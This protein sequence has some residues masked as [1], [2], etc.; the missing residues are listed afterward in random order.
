MA[1][2][3]I[4][5]R[6]KIKARIR[7]RIKGTQERPRISVF[8][9]NKHIYAQ[10][11]DDTKGQTLIS[12][13]TKSKELVEKLT[14]KL[15]KQQQAELVGSFLAQKALEANI[16]DV[17]FDRNGYKYHGRV[18]AFADGARKGGLNF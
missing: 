8:R 9:S 13:S 6:L 14:N 16:K 15:T 1:L 10:I 7:K 4:T 18:K 5:R 12:A 17:V 2:D 11:I 3:K